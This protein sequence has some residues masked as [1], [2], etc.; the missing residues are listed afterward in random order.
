MHDTSPP[1]GCALNGPGTTW[2]S[3]T[4]LQPRLL[5]LE[6]DLRVAMSRNLQ[7]PGHFPLDVI[8][9]YAGFKRR[10]TRLV[11]WHAEHPI[12]GTCTA[13]EVAY[14]HLW[15]LMESYERHVIQAGR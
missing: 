14:G 11:G 8:W 13:Y 5:D 6:D 7:L 3:L 2:A 15:D 9:H 12:L 10:L 1:G 4:A